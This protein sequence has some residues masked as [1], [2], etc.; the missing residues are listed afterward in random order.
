[1]DFKRYLAGKGKGRRTTTRSRSL[2]GSDPCKKEARE[3]RHTTNDLMDEYL[4]A[5]FTKRLHLYLQYPELRTEFTEVE[6]ENLQPEGE[7]SMSGSKR[8]PNVRADDLLTL[9]PC[10][11]KRLFGMT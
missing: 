1:M 10:C 6:R 2:E 9:K 7:H 8:I 11:V 3:M 5:D 4:Q